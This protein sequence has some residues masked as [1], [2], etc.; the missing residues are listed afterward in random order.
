MP[1]ATHARGAG[2]SSPGAGLP[3]TP[4]I[5]AR[6]LPLS[7]TPG[8]LMSVGREAPS[9]AAPIPSRKSRS[10]ASA[11]ATSAALGGGCSSSPSPSPPPPP[12]LLL[13]RAAVR[14]CWAGRVRWCCTAG[15]CLLL[16]AARGR[17]TFAAIRRGA[18]AA[19]ACVGRLAKGAATA[20]TIA[21]LRA[22]LSVRPTVVATRAALK[23]NRGGTGCA[24][25]GSGRQTPKR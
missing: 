17:D 22:H 5:R 16:L 15:C 7:H 20:A 12:L 19:A 23:E 10:M 2:G 3:R 8:R 6:P 1:A 9:P 13:L 21:L 25:A 14:C 24:R 18:A 4:C 11:S